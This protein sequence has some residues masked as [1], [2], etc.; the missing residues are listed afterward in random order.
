MVKPYKIVHRPEHP[1]ADREG[2]VPNYVLVVEEALGRYLKKGEVV[3]HVDYDPL[4]D[5][6]E[7]LLVVTKNQHAWIPTLMARFIIARDLR[8][9]LTE[10]LSSQSLQKEVSLDEKL[11][12]GEAMELRLQKR[13]ERREI[14]NKIKQKA[15][16]AFEDL[17]ENPHEQLQSP[18]RIRREGV[19]G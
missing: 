14:Q 8:K 7:N 9:E 10:W 5:S 13:L 6:P 17:P 11:A 3:H 4:N 16:Q 1:R 15:L 18:G 19:N 2:F 12:S